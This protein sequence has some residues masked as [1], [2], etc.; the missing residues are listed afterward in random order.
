MHFGACARASNWSPVL[1]LLL[2]NKL[3]TSVDSGTAAWRNAQ[4]HTR[5]PFAVPVVGDLLHDL[6]LLSIDQYTIWK[7]LIGS[8][9][10][11]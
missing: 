5:S 11:I 3:G 2:G 9:F 1:G 7:A 6:T 4:D 8:G 10:L